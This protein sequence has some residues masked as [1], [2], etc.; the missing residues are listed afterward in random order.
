MRFVVWSAVLLI[1]ACQRH[2]TGPEGTVLSSAPP[3]VRSFVS[4]LNEHRQQHGCGGL[5]WDERIADVAWSHS[6]DMARNN[7]FSHTNLHGESP[8]DRLRSEGVQFSAAAEN[9]AYGQSTGQQVM[10]SWLNSSGH[11]TNIENC[12]YTKHGVGLVQHRW[13]HVFVDD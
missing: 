13:T 3:E 8:F 2:I 11:R 4:L 6:D 12:T 10:Q 5:T 7:Y 9:I 1:T